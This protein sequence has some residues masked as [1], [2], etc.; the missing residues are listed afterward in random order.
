MYIICCGFIP[1]RTVIFL[2]VC[3]NLRKKVVRSSYEVTMTHYHVVP[4]L[5]LLRFAVNAEDL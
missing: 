3:S 2:L 5:L 4:I 1:E